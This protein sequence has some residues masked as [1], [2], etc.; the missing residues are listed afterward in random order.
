MEEP[1]RVLYWGMTDNIGGI[2]SFIMN[3][4]RNIDR[5]KVQID[6]LL[7]H[8][9]G[10]IAFEDEII[11]MGGRIYR[12]MYSEKESFIKSRT[13][14]DKFFKQHREFSAVHIH[15]NF[16]YAYPLKYAKKYHIPLRIIHA[17]NS[18][19]DIDRSTGIRKILKKVRTLRVKKQ[20]VKY[21]NRYFACSDLAADFM[22]HEKKYK[23][24]K[25]GVEIRKYQYNQ[26]YREKI[27]EELGVADD[28][29]V[30]GF[31]GRLREQKN[32]YFIIDTFREY[33]NMNQKAKLIIAGI[34]EWEQDVKEYAKDL[35]EN[36]KAFFLGKRTDAEYLYQGFDCFLLP[37]LYE[38]LPVVLVEAQIAGLPCFTSDVVTKQ[39]NITGLVNYYS[40][41]NDAKEWARLI[42]TKKDQYHL[43][44]EVYAKKVEEQGFDVKSVAKELEKIYLE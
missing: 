13:E 35:I 20:I 3:I 16:L 38:G 1:I 37:S 7:D 41:K 33:L 9:Q 8:A 40:L 18:N 34:G 22:F 10:E 2:E 32:P 5:N 36:G 44:R 24:V 17:H 28:E 25:N 30:I 21:P 11:K 27:R 12:V 4:Y 31:I 19:E 6:F 39:V 14:L 15:V 26:V 23:W 43:N 29:Y 42:Q